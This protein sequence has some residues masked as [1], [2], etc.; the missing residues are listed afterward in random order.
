MSQIN[1]RHNFLTRFIGTK[2]QE[3]ISFIKANEVNLWVTVTTCVCCILEIGLY[4]AYNRVVNNLNNVKIKYI[5]LSK[6]FFQVHPWLLINTGGPAE[7]EKM[8]KSRMD[9]ENARKK[10]QCVQESNSK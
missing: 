1:T 10:G 4:F 7:T 9:Q 8:I 5:S 2:P 3:D 6:I